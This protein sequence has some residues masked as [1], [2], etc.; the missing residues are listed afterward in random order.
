VFTGIGATSSIPPKVVAGREALGR[1]EWPEALALFESAV[2]EEPMPEALEGLSQAAYVLGEGGRSLQ[3]RERAFALYLKAGRPAEAARTATWLGLAYISGHGADAVSNGWLQRARRL[4]ED[5]PPGPEHAWLTFW[6]GHLAL[7]FQGD[8]ETARR[9]ASEARELGRR[10]GLADVDTMG[11][12]L[13]GLRLVGEGRIEEGMRRLDGTITAVLAGEIDDVDAAGQAC[14]YMLTACEQ[15]WDY[16][17]ALQWCDRVADLMRRW[18]A[19]VS[20]SFC[21]LHYAGAFLWRGDHSGAEAEIMAMIK[22]LEG[23]AP[24][25]LGQSHALLGELRRRQGRREEAAALFAEHETQPIAI[26]GRAALALDAEP[27][28]VEAAVR[29]LERFLRQRSPEDAITR[30]PA[31]RQLIRARLELG[32]LEEAR[33]TLVDLQAIAAA[34]GTCAL[35]AAARAG[36]G[37]CAA[38]VGDHGE[39]VS[40]FEDAVDDY[41]RAGSP[42][43]SALARLDLAQAL[44]ALGRCTDAGEEARGARA[45]FEAIGAACEVARADRFLNSSPASPVP[46]PE[47][48]VPG[49]SPRESEV[50]CLVARGL[51]N[52]EIAERL[53]LSEHTV[54]RH[55]ANILAKLDLPSRAAAAAHAARKGAV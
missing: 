17:R 47:G 54:K 36:E 15:V 41:R 55:V 6:E 8:A 13:E 1:R 31:L 51:S 26:L 50:L 32:R 46:A 10:L 45:A 48:S 16:E 30:A 38:A 39:A 9:K 19:K 28:D 22:E 20:L 49:L 3:A 42:Y 14:C 44:R 53:F 34:A 37:L 43:E 21:R 35:R 12:G 52:P 7:L 4:L 24:V 23:V 29:L 27:K 25:Y 2:A 40:A 18:R 11:D 33:G 5:L